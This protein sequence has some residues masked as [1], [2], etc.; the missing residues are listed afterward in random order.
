[1][2][3]GQGPVEKEGC[4]GGSLKLLTRPFGH[5]TINF[6]FPSLLQTEKSKIF[7]GWW[8]WT[9]AA[10]SRLSRERFP[11]QLAHCR[12]LICQQKQTWS[13]FVAWSERSLTPETHTH[14]RTLSLSGTHTH[15]RTHAHT[16]SLSRTH[17]H[18]HTHTRT[19]AHAQL[20]RRGPA[21]SAAAH[22]TLGKNED[23]S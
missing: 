6:R 12:V 15:A 9:V 19:H 22:V 17:T 11:W 8:I 13:R 4:N 18:T 5:W 23:L 20:K 3:G 7:V 2:H 16:L 10:L 21:R 1:M 14:A